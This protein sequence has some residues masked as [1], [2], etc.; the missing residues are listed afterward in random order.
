MHCLGTF[1]HSARST[2]LAVD[3]GVVVA[4]CFQ[5]RTRAARRAPGS[6]AIFLLTAFALQRGALQTIVQAGEILMV[7]SLTVYL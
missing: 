7:S 2:A 4:L 3:V 6:R 5:L 1:C